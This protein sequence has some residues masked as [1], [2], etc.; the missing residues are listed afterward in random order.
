LLRAVV[1]PGVIVSALLS[2]HGAPARLDL[3]WL[4]GEFELVVCPH[5][6]EE[7]GGVLLRP[8]FREVASRD[9]IQ[10]LVEVIRRG[11]VSRPDP[12]VREGL[13][14]DPA[15]DYLVALAQTSD[16]DYLV[17]VDQ[18]LT[19]LTS[20]LPPVLSPAAFLALL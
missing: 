17:S 3:R 5:L 13:T 9:E 2:P 10:E 8:K 12:V 11:A 6:L 14:R 1:D 20:V 16:V 18:D 7:L 4:G 19:T 15:D